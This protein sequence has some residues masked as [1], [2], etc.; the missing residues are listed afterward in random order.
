MLDECRGRGCPQGFPLAG[1]EETT[2][3][4]LWDWALPFQSFLTMQPYGGAVSFSKF[5]GL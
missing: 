5:E 3:D 1:A 4:N 2:V